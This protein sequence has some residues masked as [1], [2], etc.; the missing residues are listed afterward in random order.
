MPP[1]ADI[2]SSLTGLAGQLGHIF[3]YVVL[4]VLLLAGIGWLLQRR[5]GLDMP[6][7][8]RLNFYFVMPGMTYFALVT[9]N[10]SPADVGAVVLFSLA[11]IA[12]LAG[13]ALAA[14]WARGVPREHRNALLM[15]AMF[16]NSGNYGLP[17]QRLAFPDRADAA[18]S[19]QTF[20]MLTQNIVNF[21]VGVW[22]AATGRGQ[23]RWK[24]SLLHVVKFPP[25][26]SL[27]AGL[28]TIWARNALGGRA[29]AVLEAL[30]PFRESVRYVNDA[31]VAV[32]LCTLGAQLATVRH[33]PADY[34][35]KLSVVL[36][37]LIAPV[38]GL[39][40]VYAFGL[41][42]F[43]AQLLLIST[44]AP[45]AINVMLLCLHFD[46][47]PDYAARTVFYTTVL[48]PITVTLVIFLAKGGFLA[49]LG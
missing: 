22:L 35:V 16:Y 20:V 34:P 33:E 9:S 26:Y 45:T 17:L 48:S 41:S 29:P 39:G 1:L 24:D 14:A 13:V 2:S 4:P 28:L 25:L 30:A 49:R 27:A 38:I 42:G 40:L 32:A 7:L 11:M 31:F 8:T 10:V 21:T 44:S 19:L 18:F 37:L 47:H 23:I 15:T 5:L 43:L 6:T 36:R 12:C 3:Y 46:N